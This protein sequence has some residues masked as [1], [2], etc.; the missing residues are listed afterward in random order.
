MAGASSFLDGVDGSSGVWAGFVPRVEGIPLSVD[1]WETLRHLE[2]VHRGIVAREG[3]AWSD[4]WRAEQV[5]GDG[6]ALVPS[7]RGGPE[8][9]VPG[10]DGL[11][12]GVP[13][14]LLGIYVADCAAVYLVDRES[15]ALGLVHSGRKGTELG[16]VGRAVERMGEEFGTRPGDLEVAI[17][18]AIRPPHYEVDFVVE[19]ERQLGECGVGPGQVTASAACTGTEVGRYY[20][21]RIEKGKTGRMLALLGRMVE[22]EATT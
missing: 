11:L 18:P 14:V 22:P 1:K 3:F 2:P 15:G 16:V 5:H 17:S 10:V 6:I 7:E 20:S 13:G 19:I 9:I 12:T 8:R 4:L 21:Y